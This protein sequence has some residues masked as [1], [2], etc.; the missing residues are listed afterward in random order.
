MSKIILPKFKIRASAAGK[1]C[2]GSIGLTETMATKLFELENKPKARTELQEKEMQRLIYMRDNPQLPA[3][4][5]AYCEQWV[6]QQIYGRDKE[7]TSKYTSRGDASEWKALV[8]V[9]NYLG[10]GPLEKNEE[11]FEDEWTTG[12]PDALPEPFGVDTKCPWDCF[13]FPLFEETLP[14]DDY[15]W[16]G[17]V[18]MGLTGKKL[19][20]FCYSLQDTPEPLIFQEAKKHCFNTGEEFGPQVVDE[21]RE[22]LTYAN[23]DPK[24][25]TKV[26]DVHRDEEA[27][28]KIR[29]RVEL[30]RQYI[31]TIKF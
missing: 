31:E 21:M 7:F 15:F 27:I 16:Q 13:T 8:D 26:F 25:K 23:I 28:T 6:K 3:G 19:F 20:K 24:Y 18:Y 12:S 9:G 2:S 5:K 17:Q 10:L 1:I 30:C 14:E 11:Y 29:Y 22:R 4:A